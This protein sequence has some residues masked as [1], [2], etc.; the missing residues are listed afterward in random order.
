[1]FEVV[2]ALAVADLA[3]DTATD[4]EE[5]EGTGDTARR[6]PRALADTVSESAMVAV[7]LLGEVVAAEVRRDL[8]A[9][10]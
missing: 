7:V 6:F 10:E 8:S 5:P 2:E 4:E 3:V 9:R 1:M